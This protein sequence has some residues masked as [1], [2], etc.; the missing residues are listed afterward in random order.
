MKTMKPTTSLPPARESANIAGSRPLRQ[1]LC[2]ALAGFGFG[3]V[4]GTAYL[5]LGG[6]Y[7]LFIPR[8]AFIVF[9]PGFFVGDAAYNWGLSQETSKIVGVLTV[10]LAYATLAILARFAWLALKHRR[11][12]AVRRRNSK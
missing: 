5:M 2:W 8:W 4:S 11:Q 3:V 7:F 1:N 12:S 10:G 9:Y 6:E